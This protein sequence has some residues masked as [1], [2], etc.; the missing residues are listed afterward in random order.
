MADLEKE[1]RTLDQ[2]D[3]PDLWPEAER[4]QPGTA[5]QHGGP[6]R[7]VAAAVAL[8]VAAVGIG[9]A[10][11]TFIGGSA[12]R[13]PQPVMSVPRGAIAFVRV[14]GD[15]IDA[16]R[17][18]YLTNP[19]GSEVRALTDAGADGMAAAEPAWSPDGSKM[20]FV[21]GPPEHLGAY[22]GDGDIYV[23]NADGTRLIRLTEGLRT[24]GPAWS[25][26]G[27][28]IVFS[29]DQGTS[30]VV[31]NSDGTG[32]REL[33]L[34]G[35]AYPPYQSPAWS[36]DGTRI[37][38][39]ASPGPRAETNSV[40]VANIDGTGTTRI[41]HGG[42]DGTPAW[43]PDDSLL[44][45]AGPDGIYLLDVATGSEHGLTDCRF[46]ED[47]GRDSH[48]SWSPD[49]M[50]IAFARQ[51]GAG[52]TV[53]VF[54]VNADGS[55]LHQLTSGPDWNTYPR[56]QPVPA[57]GES[58]PSA[59]VTR[60]VQATTSGDF[61]G[62]GTADRA[63]FVEVTSGSVSCDRGGEVFA[64]LLSQE[65]VIRFGSG[66]TLEQSFADCQGGLCGYV[67]EPT[68]LDGDGRDELAI[69][70]SSG[71]A[72]GLEEFYRVDPDGVRP[73][74][75]AEPGDPPYVEPG[76][77]ILGGGFDSVTQSPLV[78]TVRDDG[79]RELVSIHAENVGDSLRGPWQVHTTTMVLQGDRLVVTSTDGSE[80]SFPGTS[81]IPSFTDTAPFDNGCS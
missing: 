61:D 74:V 8:V 50:R 43:S 60:C 67:F 76:P 31:M 35:Q 72:T 38:F 32:A 1:F 48:P 36:P 63:E 57:E 34:D 23:M 14:A 28:Q 7:F 65:L 41:T 80:S 49:G 39:Q 40:Y 13:S 53:Q 6:S 44:A 62:D 33:R 4:R 55:G 21:L 79:T 12:Q 58:S 45:Y 26:D 81:G 69:D 15:A 24:A 30:L 2:L 75:I 29:Q 47:C 51:D 46:R 16:A 22:A 10:V 68:D 9:L 42:L 64:R 3:A 52:T 70:V 54:V 20:A 27:T 56:W 71:G 19:T 17:E 5:R 66:R 18:I 77:A 73:L 59:S 37:A 25:P 11:R 78:C